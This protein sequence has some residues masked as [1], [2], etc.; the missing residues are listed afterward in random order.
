M[1]ATLVSAGVYV[2]AQGKLLAWEPTAHFAYLYTVINNEPKPL[3]IVRGESAPLESTH[4]SDGT[5][6]F[7]SPR[8]VWEG[9]AYRR[10]GKAYRLMSYH[11]AER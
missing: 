7:F 3:L 2:R 6:A 11:K 1:L 4:L 10:D 8:T 9:K 5:Y